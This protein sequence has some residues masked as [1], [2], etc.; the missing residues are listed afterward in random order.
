MAEGETVPIR[1]D[2]AVGQQQFQ[3]TFC[4]STAETHEAAESFAAALCRDNHLPQAAVP[5]VV[6][7]IK[8][9]VTAVRECSPATS[10]ERQAER[11]EIIR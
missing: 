11:N 6:S 3:D 9:Q 7:A 2:I 10:N 8:Q 4:W 1:I 5:T